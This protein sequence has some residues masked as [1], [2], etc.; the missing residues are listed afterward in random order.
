MGERLGEGA[1]AER[2]GRIDELLGTLEQA[3]GPTAEGALDAVALLAEVYGEALARVM[4][5]AAGDAR[6]A[7]ALM[8]DDLLGHLLA[9]HDV[10]PAPTEE[11]VSRALEGV[12]PYLRSQGRD[13]ELAGIDGDVARVRLTGGSGGCGS[14]AGMA[15][16]AVRDAVLAVAPE[17]SAVEPEGGEAAARPAT[18]IP[19]DALLRHGAPPASQVGKAP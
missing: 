18:F 3:P 6:L 8:D 16:Q 1:L 9:L 19:V 11:R 12:R 2:L 5:R 13:V 10:H 7:A 4:D 17:L 14:T 15:E